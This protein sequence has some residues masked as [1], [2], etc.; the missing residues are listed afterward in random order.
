MMTA[1]IDNRLWGTCDFMTSNKSNLSSCKKFDCPYKG[2]RCD[3][4]ETYT[5]RKRKLHCYFALVMIMIGFQT[6]L[7]YY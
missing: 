6:I 2:I 5:E 4:S 3:N 1:S 7:L